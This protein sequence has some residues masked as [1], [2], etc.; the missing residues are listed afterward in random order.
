MTAFAPILGDNFYK[1][2]VFY[3]WNESSHN[4]I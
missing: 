2:T 3:E 1:Q 4:K